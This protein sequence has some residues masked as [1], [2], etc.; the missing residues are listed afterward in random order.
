MA[1]PTATELIQRL[2]EQ[3]ERIFPSADPDAYQTWN[4]AALQSLE[5]LFGP[6]AETVLTFRFPLG[7]HTQLEGTTPE[8]KWR[9]R[10]RIA[11]R[12]KLETLRYIQGALR[13]EAIYPGAGW[14]NHYGEIAEKLQQVKELVAALPSEGPT[15][16]EP[17]RL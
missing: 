14:A 4:E 2:I 10:M 12:G 1:Q 6:S 8:S 13:A 16:Q 5:L 11:L 7:K 17:R 15:G 9:E 3:G